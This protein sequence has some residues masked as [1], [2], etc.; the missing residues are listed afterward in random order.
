M[1]I[2][3]LFERD[4]IIL[5]AP[6][7]TLRSTSNV[8]Y[9]AVLTD[10]SFPAGA[11]VG[12][13]KGVGVIVGEALGVGLGVGDG[14]GLGVGVGVGDGLGV[15]EGVGLDV[16]DGVGVGDGDGDREGVGSGAPPPPPPPEGVGALAA[17][18]LTALDAAESELSPISFLARTFA[19]YEPVANSE[20]EVE[21]EARFV[22]S[23]EVV[24]KLLK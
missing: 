15:G 21:S 7:L 16:G 5:V 24:S 23:F 6:L 8:P 19:V 4:V 1:E 3:L 22:I 20:N 2:V 9:T 17:V 13:G 11:D 14:V 10:K 18:T 12:E